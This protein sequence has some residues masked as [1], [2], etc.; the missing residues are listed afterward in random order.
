M[1]SLISILLVLML[2]SPVVAQQDE[3]TT[4][5]A[6]KEA[7]TKYEKTLKTDAQKLSYTLGLEIASSL[8]QLPVDIDLNSFFLGITDAMKGNEI[9]ISQEEAMRVRMQLAE[10]LQKKREEQQKA[11]EALAQKNLEQGQAFL[12]ENKKKEGIVTTESG[13]QYEVLKEGNG[14]KPKSTDTVKVHYQGTLIDGTVFDSSIERGEPTSFP[15]NGVIP[16][17]SEAVQLMN[18]G[19]KYRLFVPSELAYKE[20]GA[21]MLIGPNAALIFEVE[22]LEIEKS[23]AE[24]AEAETADTESTETE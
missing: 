1:K 13:L 9:A 10:T 3:A 16:G 14:E 11:I 8:A 5:P 22:L 17:W 4:Q 7:E 6:A 12:A 21:G 23:D 15:V 19:S 20:R 18:V 2:L 24:N